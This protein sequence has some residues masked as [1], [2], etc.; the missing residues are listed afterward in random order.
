MCHLW[1]RRRVPH[2]DS[3]RTDRN[4]FQSQTVPDAFKAYYFESDPMVFIHD[5]VGIYCES[6]AAYEHD[7]WIQEWIQRVETVERNQ[8]K[9]RALTVPALPPPPGVPV[10]RPEPMHLDP[11]FPY[12]APAIAQPTAPYRHSNVGKVPAPHRIRPSTSAAVVEAPISHRARKNRP[13]H[14]TNNKYRRDF[15]REYRPRDDHHSLS[16]PSSSRRR[17]AGAR[18]TDNHSSS[19]DSAVAPR[20]SKIDRGDHHELVR[21]TVT[22]E[23]ASLAL[24]AANFRIH[25][26]MNEDTPRDMF[27]KFLDQ[28]QSQNDTQKDVTTSQVALSDVLGMEVDAPPKSISHSLLGSPP[29][30][31]MV[32]SLR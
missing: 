20:P 13:T 26:C 23:Q 10:E 27:Q 31:P 8:V 30:A 4:Q 6:R 2:D 28:V 3:F 17:P 25:S 9:R 18:S 21:A 14:Y 12:M 24:K 19:G 32:L 11:P 22:V 7:Q 5:I 15:Q 1:S 29:T 16:L